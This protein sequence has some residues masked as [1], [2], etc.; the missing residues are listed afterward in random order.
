M[1]VP[2]V[3]VEVRCSWHM[4]IAAFSA[5]YDVVT[6]MIEVC[7][8]LH[9]WQQNNWYRHAY[10]C[11]AC[12]R[13]VI[14]RELSHIHRRKQTSWVRLRGTF[15][16]V[17]GPVHLSFHSE[18]PGSVPCLDSLLKHR[19]S[20][21]PA[22][23]S[24]LLVTTTTLLNIIP[25]LAITHILQIVQFVYYRAMDRT[26]AEFVLDSRRGKAGQSRAKQLWGPTE[27][28]IQWIPCVPAP[29]G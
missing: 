15:H 10:H 6:L 17:H 27:H 23:K 26:S 4:T 14:L 19:S 21:R 16:H 9:L 12:P 1:L 22:F 3:S 13:S 24:V 5:A 29:E 28:P 20:F 8:V 2:D 11:K 7:C 18:Y 25:L